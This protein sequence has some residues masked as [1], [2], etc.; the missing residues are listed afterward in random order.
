MGCLRTNAAAATACLILLIAGSPAV[1]FAQNM[2]CSIIFPA[3]PLTAEGLATPY[4]LIATDPANG[5]CNEGNADQSAFVQAAIF[6]PATHQISVYNPLV[7][8]YGTQPAVPPVIPTLPAHA[9]VALWFGFNGNNL[10]QRTLAVNPTTLTDNH[11]VNGTRGSV[12]GQFS[13][14]NAVAFFAATNGAIDRRLLHVPHRGM[15]NDGRLCPTVRSFSIVDQDQSDNLPVTYLVTPDGLFAQNTAA[16]V[17]S[18]IGAKKF[19]NPSDNGLLDRFVDPSL[20]CTPWKGA[21]LADPGQTLPALPLNEL[22]ARSHVFYQALIPA[23]DPM[24]LDNQ[25][26][27]SLAKLNLYRRGVDQPEV[28]WLGQASTAAYCHSMMHQQTNALLR[29]ETQL[30]AAPSPVASLGSNLFTFMAARLVGS[31]QILNCESF[32]V[33]NR[34]TVTTDANGVAIGAT[35]NLPAA[36][37]GRASAAAQL[38]S[39]GVTTEDPSDDQDSDASSNSEPN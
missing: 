12:F 2:D 13:Y 26:N 27:P 7:I 30:T 4:Q 22:Q 18:L 32:G 9:I 3:N 15:G 36:G 14:C 1:V 19:G 23:G 25:G 31:Y 16:N 20:S 5:P 6:D 35:I 33:K 11:C 29:R 8:D 10:T 21:D 37:G 17:S 39:A 38:S 34:V 24:V 28:R